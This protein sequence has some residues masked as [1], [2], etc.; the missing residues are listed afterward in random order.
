MV[1]QSLGPPPRGPKSLFLSKNRPKNGFL[2]FQ[3]RIMICLEMFLDNHIHTLPTARLARLSQAVARICSPRNP[4]ARYFEL[5]LSNA[6]N[7]EGRQGLPITSELTHNG[8]SVG[9]SE[10]LSF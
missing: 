7:F 8:L 2:L 5:A 6:L 10:N 3:Q 9:L 4:L 1:K